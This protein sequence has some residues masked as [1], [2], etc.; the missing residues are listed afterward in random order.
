MAEEAFGLLVLRVVVG[1]IFIAQ[2]HRKLFAPAEAS[3][4]RHNLERM[5]AAAGIPFSSRLALLVSVLELTCGALLLTGL[6]ARLACLPLIG[7][8]LVAIRVKLPTGFFGGWD[9][10][11]S[12]LGGTLALLLLGPGAI[13][14]DAWLSV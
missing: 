1:G 7:I 4:G 14:L 13:S 6:V 11:I 10:P 12:V 2:G 9:W 5:I 8:L 3:H